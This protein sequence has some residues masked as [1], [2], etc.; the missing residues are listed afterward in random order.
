MA[1]Y[2]LKRIIQ[3]VAVMMLATI[4]TFFLSSLLPGDPVL[5]VAG[6]ESLEQDTY[7]A[8][9]YSLGFDKPVVQRFFI[10]L[11]KVIH[12]DFGTSYIYHMPVWDL[13]KS[14]VAITLYLSFL[15]LFIS[16]PLG[17]LFGVITAVKRGS[18]TDSII[19]L[20]ANFTACLPQFWVALCLMYVFALKLQ[21]LPP[22]GLKWPSEV[23]WSK[24]LKSLVMPLFCIALG[25][26]A[27]FT[28]QTR[29]SVLETIRQDFVRTARSKGVKEGVVTFRH[30]LR[31]SLIPLITMLGA[32]LAHIMGGSMFVENVFAIPGMGM[33]L[34]KC[35]T[36]QDIPTIQ[37]LVL[38]TSFVTCLVFIITDI[39]YVFVDPRISLISS[40]Q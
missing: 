37:A 20:L 36:Q 39:V 31:N 33:L 32:R 10:W 28:R 4:A 34:M 18:K 17:I 5:A 22:A 8:I 23:G 21:L 35:I 19:T 26:I 40:E 30:V 2:I 13:I 16:V 29:S 1:K 24:H 9:Y 38:I 3:M 11:G 25:G 14:R 27:S 7:D 12:L 6:A 15:A